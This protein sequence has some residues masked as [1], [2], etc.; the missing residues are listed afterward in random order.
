MEGESPLKQFIHRYS[1]VKRRDKPLPEPPVAQT[2]A[3][4]RARILRSTSGNA[5]PSKPVAAD[6]QDTKSRLRAIFNKRPQNKALSPTSSRRRSQ[7]APKSPHGIRK[8]FRT[9]GGSQD[10]RRLN[11]KVSE[12]EAQ[13]RATKEELKNKST[14]TSRPTS[15]EREQILDAEKVRQQL[16]SVREKDSRYS[17]L[18]EHLLSQSYRDRNGVHRTLACKSTDDLGRAVREQAELEADSSEDESP[19]SQPT[20]RT[21]HSNKSQ[22]MLSLAVD[23]EFEEHKQRRS[24]LRRKS[25]NHIQTQLESERESVKRRQDAS[26][27]VDTADQPRSKRVRRAS[28]Y[29]THTIALDKELPPI[30]ES[31]ASST[32]AK[33]EF[34]GQP[35]EQRSKPVSTARMHR[36]RKS[37]PNPPTETLIVPK[38]SPP[39]EELPKQPRKSNHRRRQ[40]IIISQDD[41]E[42]AL[43]P[44]RPQTRGK[45]DLGSSANWTTHAPMSPGRGCGGS[46]SRLERVEEEYE[47][48][49]DVF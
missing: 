4:T 48:D 14:H 45:Q 24:S 15:V 28:S 10:L 16:A 40:S 30:Q 25:W 39:T 35:P 27:Q 41:V 29:D 17:G 43:S 49:E 2:L 7:G 20:I 44:V 6:K 5:S 32:F 19:P 21:H 22:P 46:P 1:P 13:L 23:E 18:A 42:E 11:K 26:H 3:D 12:L 47:W 33:F 37:L 38:L 8:S 34:P 31:P 36:S 9:R